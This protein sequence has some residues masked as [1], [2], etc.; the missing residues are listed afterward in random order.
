[1]IIASFVPGVYYAFY[2]RP[3]L[4]ILYISMILVLGTITASTVIDPRYRSMSIPLV[5]AEN[6]AEILP[7][8]E[9]KRTKARLYLSTGLSGLIPV[10]HCVWLE[11]VRAYNSFQFI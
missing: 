8:K 9:F 5:T 10:I 6:C 1:M 4:Q 2:C 7:A 11:G 3:M